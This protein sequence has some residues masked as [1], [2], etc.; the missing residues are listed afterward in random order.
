M[1]VGYIEG[2]VELSNFEAYAYA[3]LLFIVPCTQSLA[4]GQFFFWGNRFALRSKLAI[5]D[6]VF[7]K[8]LALPYEERQK[9]GHGTIVSHMQIDASKIAEALPY[10]HF[11]WSSPL[12]LTVALTLLYDVLGLAGLGGVAVMALIFPISLIT[13]KLQN[14]LTENVMAA[15]DKRVK[16]TNELLQAIR[17]VKL[18]AWEVPLCARLAQ[19]R[20]TEL[21]FI[22]RDGYLN[23]APNNRIMILPWPALSLHRFLCLAHSPQ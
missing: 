11:I 23:S 12:Q 19:L 5:G 13:A 22:L 7:R 2:S 15:R 20:R 14:R 17:V 4:V 16:F 9:F 10:L 18:H 8:A 1:V 6:C 21:N 3:V